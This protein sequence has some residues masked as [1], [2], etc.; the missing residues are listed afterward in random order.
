[1]RGG[2][3]RVVFRPRESVIKYLIIA[4]IVVFLLSGFGQNP[5]GM[6]VQTLAL[7]PYYIREFQVWRLF[8]YMFVHGGFFHI[9]FNM[10][11]LYLFGAP[12]EQRLGPERFLRLYFISG[13][14]GGIAWTLA[15]W[16]VVSTYQV[17]TQ[18][19]T[20]GQAVPHLVN[21]TAKMVANSPDVVKVV[22]VSGI[23]LGA[24][25]GVFGVMFA[26]AMAFPNMQL[27]LL[28]PPI[29]LRVRTFVF[30]YAGI[31]IWS[32]WGQARGHGSGIAHLAHLGGLLGA[33]FYMKHLGFQSPYTFFRDWFR[34]LRGQW[35]RRKMKVVGGN[36]RPPSNGPRSQDTP[37]DLESETD[38]I[39]DKIGTSGIQS[40]T[41]EERQTLE[42]ARDRLRQRGGR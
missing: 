15:N 37:R 13:V 34:K 21:S 26:C 19:G 11:G 2:Q 18:T 42:A 39:L 4:N 40:L 5:T 33:F 1:M 31:E 28:F 41:P 16:N 38:R 17:L 24:S 22:A 32:A 20:L 27:M 3:R 35:R 23:V 12:V 10:W 14:V 36:D 29:P 25:G 7:H 8:T 9:F 30:I 6:V